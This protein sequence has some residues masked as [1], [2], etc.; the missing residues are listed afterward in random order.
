MSPNC[1]SSAMRKLLKL[2]VL[3]SSGDWRTSSIDGIRTNY[4]SFDRSGPL[5]RFL[6]ILWSRECRV[7][8]LCPKGR[9]HVEVLTEEIVGIV[10]VLGHRPAINHDKKARIEIAG[11]GNA[12]HSEVVKRK[13]L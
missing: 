10:H 3:T 5:N 6:L 11:Q 8:R 9:I 4:S 7:W 1:M 13:K 2:N 12:A